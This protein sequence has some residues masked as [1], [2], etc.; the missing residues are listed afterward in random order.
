MSLHSLSSE[1]V[2]LT[3]LA[4][5]VDKNELDRYQT[6]DLGSSK[7]V[8][9]SVYQGFYVDTKI[10]GTPKCIH[11][12]VRVSILRRLGQQEIFQGQQFCNLSVELQMQ[13]IHWKNVVK[14]A[15]RWQ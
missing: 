12:T 2:S 9:Y 11:E 4:L 15:I 13:F 3:Q 7:Y 5:A 6:D 14:T 1:Y 8:H 10:L